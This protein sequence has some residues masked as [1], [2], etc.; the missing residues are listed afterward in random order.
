MKLPFCRR[1]AARRRPLSLLTSAIAISSLVSIP[2]SAITFTPAP[3]ANLDLSP[4][5]RV[6]AVG[7]FSGISLYEYEEQSEVASSSNSS[8]ALLARMPNGVFA[9]IVTTDASIQT[10]CAFTLK[11]GTAGGVVLGGNF[12]SLGNLESPAIALFNPNTSEITPLS[13]LSGQVSAVLCDQDTSTVY[14]GGNFAGANSTNAI[15]WVGG[16]GWTNLP[17]AGF[18]GPVTSITKA[19]NGHII[20]GGSFTGIGNASM[21]QSGGQIINFST[22]NITSGSS[23]TANGFSDPRNIICKTSG[24]DAAGNTWLLENDTAGYWK[25]SFNFG[26][27]PDKLRLW[28]THEDGRGTKTWRFTA[29]PIDGI[30]NFTYIDPATGQNKSCTSECP[31]SN[32][33]SIT[34]QDFHFVNQVGMNAFRIDI[35]AFYGD[36]GG[37]DGIE[38]FESDIFTYAIDAFNEPTCAG[39]EFASNATATGPWSVT[40]SY[41]S[42]SEYLTANI[43]SPITAESAS[44]VFSPDITESGHY[45]VN[46]YTPGCIQD[47]SCSTRGQFV[48]TG[49]MTSDSTAS[50]TIN[51]TLYQ[52]ND[53]DKYDQ[54]YFGQIDACS[55]SFRPSVTMTPL[56]GQSL[57]RMTFVAQRVGF[58]QINST[59]GLNGLFEYNPSSTVVNTSDFST[60]AFDSLGSSFPSGSAVTALATSG[61]LT[62]IAG[63]FSSGTAVNIVAVN[64]NSSST[65]SLDGGLNGEVLSMYADGT[66]L[67]AGGT[68]NS[69]EDNSTE[70]LNNVAVYDTS[71]NSWVPLGSG[72]DGSVLTVVP[73]TMNITSTTPELVISFTGDFVHLNT[74]DDNPAVVANGFGIW[75][76]SQNNW[77]SNLDLPIEMIEGSLSSSILDL[78][79]G[80]SLYAGS[81]SSAT[82][83]SNGA[84]TLGDT[85]GLFPVD[86]E[87]STS[88]SS[89][90]LSKRD[91]LSDST[92]SGV[93]TGIFDSNDDRNITILAGHFTAKATNGSEIYNLVFIDGSDNN[94]V[95]GLGSE[96]SED[97]TFLALAVEGN[98]LFAGGNVTGIIDGTEV[99]G[100]VSYNLANKEYNSQP[101]AL[102]GGN[103]TVTSIV[104]RPDTSD[105][106]VGGTFT[107]AGSLGCPGVCYFDTS[108]GQWNQ[109]GQIR[110]TVNALLWA[111]K[112]S[113]IA[114]GN[115]TVNGN[116]SFL[117]SYD[118]SKQTWASFTGCDQ[119]PGPVE[120]VTPASEDNSQIWVAGMSSNGS[121]YLMKYDGSKWESTG[122]NLSN[123]EIRGLQIF[124][125]TTSHSSSPLVDSDQALMLTG[126]IAIP[127][128]GTAAAALFNGT[129][130]KPY[131]ITVGTDN[132]AGSLSRIFSEKQNFFTAKS[133][134]LAIGFIVLIGLAISLVLMLLIVVAGLFLD[135]VRKKR[136]GYVPAPT[137]MYDRGSGIQRI[138]PE[139][140]LGNVGKAR[141]G[142]P[143]V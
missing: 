108:S 55:S 56:A 133:N 44:V 75:V 88:S 7:D 103:E 137:S 89:S 13:G 24:D 53:Y 70:G 141:Q 10:M 92:L 9:P 52:T 12:T 102:S 138:P 105:V 49:Q 30:M 69:T 42:N 27:Q 82:V 84:V 135:R 100:L 121:A 86:I 48:I 122:L 39:L 74:F 18:N 140:L 61:D 41:S 118:A 123:S 62:F 68:F 136:E 83:A 128:F 95:T 22:A 19:S 20:F 87:P 99:H 59:G 47:D 66:K 54:I 79:G 46:V 15:A 93:A 3:S 50:T 40:P 33:T 23:T 57:D 104:V 5:G 97:S 125:L 6:A 98:D 29:L 43:S 96:I 127:G 63:N 72:V 85:L 77:L 80:G 109:P 110:G 38:L 28:N 106:Y 94:A 129:T 126:S 36:G 131:A 117:V 21:P 76:P 142:V 31:L 139:E 124:P 91:T 45:S 113:L 134:K 25:A 119:I 64:G 16:E 34:Y 26:F 73:L 143:Q 101:P 37:L 112:S 1:H 4:L 90:G 8:Q 115:L 32:D 14:V 60:S 132:G 71:N 107:S 51:Q 114:G 116:S 130:L 78:P 58:T 81:V 111:S 17:F 11:N 35:S 67:F 2:A 65:R 120:V